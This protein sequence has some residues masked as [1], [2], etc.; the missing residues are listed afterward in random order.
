MPVHVEQTDLPYTP[1]QVFDLVA[2]IESYPKFLPHVVSA[3]IRHRNN[4]TLLVDQVVQLK[5]LRLPFTTRAVLDPPSGIHVVCSDSLFGSFDDQWHFTAGPRGGTHLQC[6]TTFQFRSG[7]L[8]IA[9]DSA[10]GEVMRRT[11]QAFEARAKKLYG[12][13]ETPA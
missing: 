10:L 11:V 13:A 5:V 2:D 6:R 7:L 12:A 3:R 1:Q 4:N 9:F 8:R